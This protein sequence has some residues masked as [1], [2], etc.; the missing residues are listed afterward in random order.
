[1]GQE[2]QVAKIMFLTLCKA[3]SIFPVRDVICTV[4]A[5]FILK[6][7]RQKVC[8]CR[9]QNL[10]FVLEDILFSWCNNFFLQGRR[11]SKVMYDSSYLFWEIKAQSILWIPSNIFLFHFCCNNFACRN[12]T[13][14]SLIYFFLKL[15]DGPCGSEKAFCKKFTYYDYPIEGMLVFL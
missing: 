9:S 5:C 1:M 10:R 2:S 12:S 7:S 8:H 6:S 3:F 11:F 15:Q 4:H 14:N 13:S